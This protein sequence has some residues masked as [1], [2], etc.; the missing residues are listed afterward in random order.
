MCAPVF[1]SSWLKWMSFCFTAEY[2]FTGTLTKPKLIDPDQIARGAMPA[3]YPSAGR[4]QQ[5]RLERGVVPEAEHAGQTL[6]LGG[7]EEHAGIVVERRGLPGLAVELELVEQRPPGGERE[8]VGAMTVEPGD[9]LEE[10]RR[11]RL[12]LRPHEHAGEHDRQGSHR[13]SEEAELRPLLRDVVALG[14]AG[15]ATSPVDGDRGARPVPRRREP[16]ALGVVRDVALDRF[17]RAG[18]R[19]W[20]LPRRVL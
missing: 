4:D 12:R 9:V 10:Q 14:G 20:Q 2:S 3:L 18:V 11:G 8:R 6:R 13:S 5:G 17:E 1:S 15:D 16:P 19:R 7:G